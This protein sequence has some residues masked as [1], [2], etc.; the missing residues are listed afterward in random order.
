MPLTWHYLEQKLYLHP[1]TYFADDFSPFDSSP[2]DDIN[3]DET[4]PFPSVPLVR[5]PIA[6]GDLSIEI[7]EGDGCVT[8]EPGAS[9]RDGAFVRHDARV[10]QYRDVHVAIAPL[11][12]REVGPVLMAR[13]LVGLRIPSS[14]KRV[15]MVFGTLNWIDSGTVRKEV[16]HEGGWRRVKLYIAP[17]QDRLDH[18]AVGPGDDYTWEC[19]PVEYPGLLNSGGSYVVYHRMSID[20]LHHWL[21]GDHAL[22]GE[23][24]ICPWSPF[25]GEPWNERPRLIP[26]PTGHLSEDRFF[27]S[28]GKLLPLLSPIRTSALYVEAALHKGQIHGALLEQATAL[29]RQA[30]QL[31]EHRRME[32]IAAQEKLI[33]SWKTAQAPPPLETTQDKGKKQ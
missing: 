8:S 7:E 2:I 11:N 3:I 29:R 1:G 22:D 25:E 24:A 31:V 33:A 21:I 12:D 10:I 20:H 13:G 4:F 23:A 6:W 18:Q 14:S 17:Y 15:T 30:V 28:D 19:D 16:L 5:I 32:A 26:E 27:E 9:R